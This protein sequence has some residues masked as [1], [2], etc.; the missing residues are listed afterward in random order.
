MKRL[1]ALFLLVGCQVETEVK[2]IP[3][4]EFVVPKFTPT[5]AP[6]V[7]SLCKPFVPDTGVFIGEIKLGTMG[8]NDKSNCMQLVYP[9]FSLEGTRTIK[10]GE[11]EAVLEVRKVV[12][13]Q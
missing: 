8:W 13:T 5:M 11:Y 6:V 9:G 1:L 10:V 4:P 12:L 2:P 7:I 3:M